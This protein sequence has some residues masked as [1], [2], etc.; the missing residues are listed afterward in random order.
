MMLPKHLSDVVLTHDVQRAQLESIV[1]K[2]VPFPNLAKNSFLLHGHYGS[3]KTTLVHMLTA[4]LEHAYADASDQTKYDWHYDYRGCTQS[5]TASQAGMPVVTPA[6]VRLINCGDGHNNS[7]ASEISAIKESTKSML[8]SFCE[9][10]KFKHI[11]L[12]ELDNWTEPA[13]AKLKAVMSSSPLSCVFYITTNHK[14]K[15]DAGVR[16]RSIEF[17]LNGGNA[18][19]YLAVLR[20]FYPRLSQY[21]DQ[22]LKDAIEQ[23]RGD[24][25]MLHEIALTMS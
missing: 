5:V 20:K 18:N 24:W 3:G 10:G 19:G 21:S 15:I 1:S 12:D 23:A 14:S 9:A 8:H 7:A 11:I 16:S 6:D 13:Q 25:R 17:E 4:L 2:R 22:K